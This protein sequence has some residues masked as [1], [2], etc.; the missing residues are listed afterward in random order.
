MAEY[1][2]RVDPEVGYDEKQLQEYLKRKALL[3][4][5]QYFQIIRH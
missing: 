3:A 1:D 4:E 2:V 5:G